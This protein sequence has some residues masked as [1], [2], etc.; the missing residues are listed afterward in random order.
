MWLILGIWGHMS[1]SKGRYVNRNKT[2][3]SA[4]T[5]P[6]WPRFGWKLPVPRYSRTCHSERGVG[7]SW[8]SCW[9]AESNHD[10]RAPGCTWRWSGTAWSVDNFSVGGRWIEKPFLFVFGG[11]SLFPT[12]LTSCVTQCGNMLKC[13]KAAALVFSIVACMGKRPELTM[14]CIYSAHNVLVVNARSASLN[15]SSTQCS[16][17]LHWLFCQ[18]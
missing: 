16:N 1:I 2:L 10:Q 4:Q 9:H 7:E 18:I 8:G 11:R 6:S 15:F 14:L 13:S 12:I 17:R 5:V 3:S